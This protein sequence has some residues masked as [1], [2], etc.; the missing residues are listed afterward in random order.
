MHDVVDAIIRVAGLVGSLAGGAVLIAMA[1]GGYEP[2]IKAVA[3]MAAVAMILGGG[4]RARV[5]T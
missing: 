5:K 3:Y 1:L 2:D 4:A